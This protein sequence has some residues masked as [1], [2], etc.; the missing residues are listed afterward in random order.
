MAE[1]QFKKK[2]I[3]KQKKSILSKVITHS[4]TYENVRQAVD[5][6]FDLFP[7]K[8][9]GKKIFIKRLFFLAQQGMRFFKVFGY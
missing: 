4:A 5:R 2:Y 6:V 7:M 9:E 8:L 3:F 1:A